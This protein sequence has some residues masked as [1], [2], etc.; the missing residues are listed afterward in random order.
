MTPA[1][2]DPPWNGFPKI[3]VFGIAFQSQNRRQNLANGSGFKGFPHPNANPNAPKKRFGFPYKA[4]LMLF[5]VP[6]V[7]FSIVSLPVFNKNTVFYGHFDMLRLFL[8]RSFFSITTTKFVLQMA[9]KRSQNQSHGASKSMA[10]TNF[11][12]ATPQAALQLQKQKQS[13]PKM[14]PKTS[15]SNWCVPT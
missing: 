3:Y 11:D 10:L 6:G 5:P 7:L 13:A 15:E 2:S 1:C 12:K 9:S 4:L 8:L 14:P